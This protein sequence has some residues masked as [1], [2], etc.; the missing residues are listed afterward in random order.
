[1][2]S[3]D[4]VVRV[5][6][7]QE[8]G[9]VWAFADLQ[10]GLLLADSQASGPDPR[11][12]GLAAAAPELFASDRA[13]WELIFGHLPHGEQHAFQNIVLVSR[14]HVHVAMRCSGDTSVALIAVAPRNRSVGSIVA[15]ARGRLLQRASEPV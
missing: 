2:N 10:C 3:I 11:L 5:E 13:S 8:V 6:Q 7:Q 4:K 12:E 14:E 9:L 15:E 1:V